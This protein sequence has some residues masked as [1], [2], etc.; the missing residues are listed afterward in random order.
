MTTMEWNGK[1]IAVDADRH[2]VS[3]ADWTREVAQE[4]ASEEGIDELT[5]GHWKVIDNLRREFESKCQN[6]GVDTKEFYQLFPKGPGKKS[7]RIAGLP[8]PKSCV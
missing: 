4:I 8:K 5:E 3:L 1:S 6:S 7:A 2:L